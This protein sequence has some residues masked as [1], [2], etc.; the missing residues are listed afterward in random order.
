MRWVSLAIL[1]YF[2]CVLQTTLMGFIEIHTVRPL[3]PAMAAAFYALLARRGDALIAAWVFGL[4]V[5][6]CGLSLPARSTVGVH[7]LGYGLAALGVL[8]IR[9]QF[10]RDHVLTFVLVVVWWAF[11]TEALAGLHTVWAVGAPGRWAEFML[12]AGYAAAYSALVCPYVHWFLRRLRVRLG[13]E[14]ARNYRG[15]A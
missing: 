14:A 2:V 12:V 4:A 1:V 5:D 9:E 6:L 11:V 15:R 8:R 13:L 3:L 10:Y 7:A